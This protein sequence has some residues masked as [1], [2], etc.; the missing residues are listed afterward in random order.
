MEIIK[1]KNR[2]LTFENDLKLGVEQIDEQHQTLFRLTL[3]VSK[4]L[5]KSPT[6][7]EI[8]VCTLE[9]EAYVQEHLG[10][11][12]TLMS[13]NGS[14]DFQDHKQL[15]DDFTKTARELRLKISNSSTEDFKQAANEVFEILINWLV[16][17]IMNVD[18]AAKD[19]MI[20]GD[21]GVQPRA[22][23]INATDNVVVEL[24]GEQKVSGFIKN[25]GPGSLLI[26]LTSSV[27]QWLS[28]GVKVKLDLLPL[29]DD[30]EVSCSV[31]RTYPE[32]NVVVALDE[33]LDIN[34][35]AKL[36]KG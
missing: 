1:Y 14:P 12:E 10:F 30:G 36:I 15:H 19:Y 13:K 35:I 22:P 9:L 11:E 4:L 8:D 3:A 33:N 24:S 16:E 5:D 7:D 29:G 18:K 17:H 31:T 28:D 20:P 32:G 27:P 25:V 6:R 2:E 23:R 34:Q 21:L 26:S